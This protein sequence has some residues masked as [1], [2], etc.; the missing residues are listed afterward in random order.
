MAQKMQRYVSQPTE[1]GRQEVAVFCED[2]NDYV[3]LK[4]EIYPTKDEADKRASELN[5]QYKEDDMLKT[6]L[7]SF[8]VTSKE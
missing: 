8:A 1:D 7:R 4:G 2:K 3:S 6:N 5:K